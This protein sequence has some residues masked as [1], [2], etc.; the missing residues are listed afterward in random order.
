MCKYK[1][2]LIMGLFNGVL[3]NASEYKVEAALKEYGHLLSQN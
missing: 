1:E 2:V 3:G